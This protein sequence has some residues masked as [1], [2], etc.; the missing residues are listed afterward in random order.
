[1]T[2]CCCSNKAFKNVFIIRR[3][4]KEKWGDRRGLTLIEHAQR[5]GS[6]SSCYC[7][8]RRRSRLRLMYLKLVKKSVL[9]E[10]HGWQET[11]V[12]ATTE[13]W[14]GPVPESTTKQHKSEWLIIF[15]IPAY[16][17][18]MFTKNTCS[19]SSTTKLFRR[20]QLRKTRP[21][22]DNDNKQEMIKQNSL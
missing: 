4:R 5:C 9:I 22:K 8:S 13:N 7:R 18:T 12:V 19:S 3:R 16:P 17:H 10:T 11:S 20:P 2:A 14:P 15:S 21:P 1:M 6:F